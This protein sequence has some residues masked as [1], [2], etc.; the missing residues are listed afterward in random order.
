M[1]ECEHCGCQGIAAS[2]EFCPQCFKPR[3]DPSATVA[4]EGEGTPAEPVPVET[5]VVGAPGS[6]QGDGSQASSLPVTAPET[7][8][9]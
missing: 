5:G 7:K 8:G 1:W 9:W 4:V 3:H 6:G 2:L